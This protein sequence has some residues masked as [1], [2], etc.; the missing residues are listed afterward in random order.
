MAYTQAQLDAIDAAIVDGVLTVKYQ[1]KLTTYRSLDELLRIRRLIAGELNPD[2]GIVSRRS[3]ASVSKGLF[4]TG[5][6]TCK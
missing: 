6:G 3:L 5:S 4:P 1:D 2:C